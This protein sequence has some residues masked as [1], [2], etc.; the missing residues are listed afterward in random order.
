LTLELIVRRTADSKGGDVFIMQL[1]LTGGFVGRREA[2]AEL[3]QRSP[4]TA[5]LPVCC[6]SIA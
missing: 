4:S 6:Q 2:E 5:A 1:F 3:G